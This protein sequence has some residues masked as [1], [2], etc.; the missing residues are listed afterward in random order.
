MILSALQALAPVALRAVPAAVDAL[1]PEARAERKQLRQ[2]RQQMEAGQLGMSAAQKAAITSSA[3]RNIRAGQRS[4]AA[5]VARGLAAGGPQAGTGAQ[6]ALASQEKAIAS[7]TGEANLATEQA[8]TQQAE[9]RKGD[10]LRRMSEQRTRR[11]ATVAD[12]AATPLGGK[13]SA[14]YTGLTSI[15]GGRS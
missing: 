5:E 15:F 12:L 10:I 1:S 2:D 11:A 7:A 13:S 3:L 4:S 9:A 6:A 8:S 14:D